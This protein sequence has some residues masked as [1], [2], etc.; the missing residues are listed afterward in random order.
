MCREA[1][2]RDLKK[3]HVGHIRPV[4]EYGMISNCTAA[5]SNTETTINIQNQAMHM[6]TGAIRSTPIS[7]LENT[8]DMQSLEDRSKIKVLTLT[9][10][11]KKLT[12]YP[13]HSRIIKPAKERLKRSSF[14]HHCWI[15]EL[16]QP[17]LLDH[18]QELIRTHAAVP[19]WE[20]H[21][22]HNHLHAHPRYRKK[23]SLVRPCEKI[24]EY[25][26]V[27]YLEEE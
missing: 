6:K 22:F 16:Q 23:S 27:N 9:A 24:L 19:C 3:L 1:H 18:M 20:R 8:T 25:I 21:K 12:D 13:I 7:A 11:F 26:S 15:F 5:K 14:S 2:Q 4:L 10:K 17:E